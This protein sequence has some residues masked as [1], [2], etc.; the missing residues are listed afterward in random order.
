VVSKLGKLVEIAYPAVG[1]AVAEPKRVSAN[2]FCIF[3]VYLI[4]YYN[5]G[6]VLLVF[7]SE[8]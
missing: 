5:I 8:F 4:Y 3:L 2:V 6:F 7:K 1:A